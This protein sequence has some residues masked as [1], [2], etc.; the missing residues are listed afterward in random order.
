M[1]HRTTSERASDRSRGCVAFAALLAACAGTALASGSTA[2]LNVQSFSNTGLASFVTAADGGPIAVRPPAGRTEVEPM[3][4][5]LEYGH[6]FGV[7]D[8]VGQLEVTRTETDWIGHTHT[9]YQQI[10]RGVRVFSGVLKVHQNP[11][12]DII[13]ANGDF[14]PVSSKLHTTPI[15]TPADA[16]SIAAAALEKGW[17]EVEQSELVLVDPGWYGDPPIG[18]HLAYYVI[19]RDMSAAIREAF[20]VDAH[21]GAILDRWSMIH[22]YLYRE[23][24][25][26]EGTSTLPGTLVRAEGDPGILVDDDVNA[27]YD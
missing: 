27:A 22:T 21:T 1:N 17:P 5:L 14:Y 23:I 25:D 10:H 12:G 26:G 20:F 4:F 15:L 24:Y 18:A 2:D 7:N 19:L 16:E 9:T 6:V 8:P 13:A 11:A 3:D